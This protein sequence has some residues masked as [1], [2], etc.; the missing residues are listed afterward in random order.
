M[1]FGGQVRKSQCVCYSGT[2]H[3]TIGLGNSP[4]RIGVI[5]DDQLPKRDPEQEE[6]PKMELTLSTPSTGRFIEF[7]CL[8][9]HQEYCGLQYLGVFEEC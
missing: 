4:F 2:K 3:F 5:V 8:T 1:K 7:I 9:W 6:A